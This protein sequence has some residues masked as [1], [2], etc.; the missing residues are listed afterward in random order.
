MQRAN[1]W[2]PQ[3]YGYAV[4]LICVII[5]LVSTHSI[6]DSAFDYANPMSSG[7]VGGY[8]GVPPYD[9]YRR[10]PGPVTVGSSAEPIN[11]S[12]IPDTAARR[13]YKEEHKQEIAAARF[14]AL[15]SLVSSIVFLLLATTMFLLHWR[16][17]RRI[18]AEAAVS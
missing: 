1:G 18:G 16:W 15:R 7:M 6:I 10:G 17:I 13:M 11:G 9:V 5:V 8:S 4:C 3:V 12:S 2:I 14:R